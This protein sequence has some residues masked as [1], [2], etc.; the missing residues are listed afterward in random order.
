VNAWR[1]SRRPSQILDDLCRFRG[2]NC[3]LPKQ[4]ETILKIENKIFTLD[5]YGKPLLSVV[6]LRIGIFS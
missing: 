5:Q 2:I 4:D 3:I 6:K 1:D